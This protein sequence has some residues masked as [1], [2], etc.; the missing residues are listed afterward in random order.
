MAESAP[1]TPE[2]SASAT[3]GR[4]TTTRLNSKKRF[5]TMFSPIQKEKMFQFAEKDGWKMQKE[6]TK[7]GN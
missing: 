5:R 7:T 4:I 2:A 1:G 3:P 6:K